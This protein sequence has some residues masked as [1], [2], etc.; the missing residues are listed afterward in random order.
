MPIISA[1]VGWRLEDQKL[2]VLNYISLRPACM[3][4][5]SKNKRKKKKENVKQNKC[6]FL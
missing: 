2:K 5:I 1:L 3:K 4:S 6:E